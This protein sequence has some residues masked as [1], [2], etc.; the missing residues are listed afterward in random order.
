MERFQKIEKRISPLSIGKPFNNSVLEERVEQRRNQLKL[1]QELRSKI[2][3]NLFK[4]EAAKLN[5]PS[6]P[7]IPQLVGRGQ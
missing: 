3:V 5:L 4:G 1:G 2:A 7:K 6:P